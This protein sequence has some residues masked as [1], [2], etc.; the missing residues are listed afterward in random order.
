MEDVVESDLFV[1]GMQILGDDNPCFMLFQV[2]PELS[3]ATPVEADYY[4]S[5]RPL[6][7]V[8]GFVRD[9]CLCAI[10]AGTSNDAEG[11]KIDSVLKTIYAVVL[12]ICETCKRQ[13][14][15]TLVGRHTHNGKAIQE[16]LDCTRM[17]EALEAAQ[18]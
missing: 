6:L 7:A 4:S 1:C 15:K 2:D 3:C 5:K 9:L 11:G 8:E 16:R 10:C 13:G 18:T 12:P 14:F 17:R